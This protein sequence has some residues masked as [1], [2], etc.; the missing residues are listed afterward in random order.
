MPD[1]SLTVINTSIN[2]LNQILGNMYS[3]L[4]TF[5]RTTASS[6]AAPG[7][8]GTISFSS[9]LA[10]GFVLLQTSSGATVKLPYYSNP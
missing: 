6:S 7:T 9:S 4:Q 8:V 10:T 2:A 5:P 3:L 1:I